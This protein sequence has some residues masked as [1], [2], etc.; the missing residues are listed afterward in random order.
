MKNI[1]RIF[2]FICISLGVNAF[3]QTNVKINPDYQVN[4]TLDTI[5]LHVDITNVTDL[6]AFSVTI[7][8][9]NS[10]L[11][12]TER[13]DG[14]FLETNPGGASVQYQ[15]YPAITNAYDSL[16]VDASILG[17]AG[18][19]GSG[20]LF[21]L[22]FVPLVRDTSVVKISAMS[23][24]NSL[25]QEIPATK[26]SAIIIIAPS[27]SVELSIE[28]Q[29]VI[30][31][32]YYFDVYLK[33]TGTNDLFLSSSD[34]ILSFDNSF[35]TSPVLTKEG[36]SPNG[37]CTFIPTNSNPANNLATQTL[38]FGNTTAS[39]IN[40]NL[41]KISIN[42]PT[43]SNQ[44]TFDSQIAKINNSAGTHR[45]GRFKMT[46]LVIAPGNPGLSWRIVSP[47]QTF[48]NTFA[49]MD[50][51]CNYLAAITPIDPPDIPIANVKIIP[52]YTFQC[53]LDT[54]TLHVDVED[55]KDL[56]SYSITV[57]YDNSV[58]KLTKV[59]EGS[60]LAGNPG[61]DPVQFQHFP[62]IANA[63]DSVIVDASIL[64]LAGSTGD[65]RLF[66]LK[67]VPIA[68]DTAVVK[69]ARL[70]FRDSQN[71]EIF[72][73]TDSAVIVLPPSVSAEL[74]VENQSVVGSDFF[75]DIYIT[76]TGTNDLYLSSSDFI[77]AFN[78]LFFN[79]PAL[80]KVGTSPGNCTFV[81]TTQSPANN[82]ATQTLYFDNTST[83]IIPN[84]S[85]G[86]L[87]KISLTIPT[88][89]DQTTFDTRIARIDN[90]AST[91]RLGTFKINGLIDPNGTS[92]LTWRNIAPDSTF[93]NTFHTKSPWCDYLA[94]LTLI[95]PPDIPLP[96]E[97]Y[98]FSGK[99]VGT[100]IQLSWS[101][102]TETENAGFEIERKQLASS[103]NNTSSFIKIGF[104][105]G[106]GNSNSPKEY[107]FADNNITSSG[108][109]IYRLKQIN[110]SGSFTYS[111][112]IEINAAIVREFALHQNY[113][114]P[115]N[116]STKIGYSV[117]CAGAECIGLVQLKIYDVLGNEVA[118]L[119]N[120]YQSA[121]TYEV[122]FDPASSI[123]HPASG[124][125]FYQL[126]V[127]SFGS[128]ELL[129]SNTKKLV[130]LR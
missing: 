88:P 68:R 117:A 94:D 35:F 73:Y 98:S 18:S 40:T 125:Y 124:I 120:E 95:N 106:H 4:C 128:S 45:L 21:S 63:L 28:N 34:F 116:P 104:V 43:P 67:F 48:V 1:F 52:D 54:I 22:K 121:G 71:R 5:T 53:S 91:H 119:V 112:A 66:S 115:F 6:L 8:Y 27:V 97:L 14:T 129:F 74:T 60:F 29:A 64:G 126:K 55:V 30:G 102:L 11:K 58:L 83:S 105:Q 49:N 100:N 107:S 127:F 33:R 80:S 42:I 50:P 20:R 90:A 79:S 46:G 109:Y 15:N 89:P 38:Y 114:N 84:P 19:S 93:V 77:I 12:L 75:F 99:Q 47:N 82:L 39:I 13:L 78:D 76:R 57:K 101:T 17:I 123:R 56:Y 61:G 24:R 87:L 103:S 36:A 51:W 26:D 108:K 85:G 92:G 25:N 44:T 10:L 3:A 72:A 2:V 31:T 9:D 69:I 23:L 110:S 41:I 81:P 70:Y 122:E 62:T 86:K 65:G 16:I 59:I 7:K 96:V 111:P 32:D 130:L 113:P 37:Y 118:T